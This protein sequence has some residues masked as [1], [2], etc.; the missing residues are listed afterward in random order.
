MFHFC[1]FYTEGLIFVPFFFL[2]SHIKVKKTTV[3]CRFVVFP[4]FMLILKQW[5]LFCIVCK[6]GKEVSSQTLNGTSLPGITFLESEP[7]KSA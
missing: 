6:H 4:F 2:P 3:H 1:C 5:L 7:P